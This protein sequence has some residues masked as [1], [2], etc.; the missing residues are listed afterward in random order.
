MKCGIVLLL[1]VLAACIAGSLISQEESATYYTSEYSG[2]LSTVILK[3]GLDD[4]FHA[5][6]FAALT[7][8]L[9]LNLLLC[10]LVHFPQV[11]KKMQTFTAEQAESWTKGEAELSS[12]SIPETLFAAMGFRRVQR[13]TSAAGQEGC[14]AARNRAGVWGAWLTHLGILIIIV[15]FALSQAFTVKYTVYGVPGQTKAVEG[16]NYELT[17]DSF[18]IP[19]REDETVVQYLSSLTLTDTATGEQRSGEASVNHPL[20]L[21]GMKI[22]QNSTGWAA[23]AVV[24]ENG[25]EIQREIVCAGEYTT[26]EAIDELYLVFR[27]FYP[28]YVMS[29]GKPATATSQLNNPAYLYMLYYGDQL[30]G[31]NVLMSDEEITVEGLTIRFEDPRPYTLLQL[32]HDPFTLLPL[33]GGIVLMA[34]LLLAFY[35]RPEELCALEENGEWRIYARSPKGGVLYR[36]KLREKAE[37]LEK[38]NLL[39]I[40]K[41]RENDE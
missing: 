36:E 33:A 23:D 16:T 25:E 4:V 24:Y 18:E 19:L 22:Y 12:T 26:I 13:F 41:W 21:F 9:C 15:G 8:L 31:M 34:A 17:I 3:L 30:L 11:L 37:E 35:F 40:T 7:G 20:Q 2:F 1:L 6:W 5:S 38:A 39:T 28:D 32:K 29:S 10:N 27:A 14:Y